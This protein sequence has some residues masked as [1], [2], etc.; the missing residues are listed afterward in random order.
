MLFRSLA[1]K[2][3]MIKTYAGQGIDD[4]TATIRCDMTQFGFHGYVLSASGTVYIDPVS[5]SDTRNYIVYFKKEIP[6]ELFNLNCEMDERNILRHPQDSY[7]TNAVLDGQLRTY[8]LALAATYEYVQYY[9]GNLS[10][11]NSGMATTLNRVNGIYEREVDVHI[12]LV[13]NNDALVFTTPVD[14]YTNSSGYTMMFENQYY[15]DSI[16]GK[17][18]YDIGHVFSTGG[19]GIASVRCVCD[20]STKAQGVTG[21]SSPVGEIGRAHV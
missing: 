4:R 18:N 3:P 17:P 14:P 10:G 19:G 21:L 11:A 20:D 13:A 2:Y 1:V 6:E 12:N 8:R 7:S 5:L 9:G 16:I 15:I